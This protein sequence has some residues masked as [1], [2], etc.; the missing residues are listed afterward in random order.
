MQICKYQ[1]VHLKVAI[2]VLWNAK[3]GN[4]VSARVC[5]WVCRWV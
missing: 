2:I 5:G 3:L 4:L 1:P